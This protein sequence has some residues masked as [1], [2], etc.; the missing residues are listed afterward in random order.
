MKNLNLLLLFFL[1]SCGNDSSKSDSVSETNVIA[2]EI[3]TWTD[4]FMTLINDH[5]LTK[6]L[7]PLIHED[8][9]AQIVKIHSENMAQGKV[10]FGH[11]G[12]TARCNEARDA[13]NGGNWCGENVANGQKTP[14]LVFNAW[15]NSSGHKANIE[16]EKAT[17]T[18]F[19]FAKNS[20]GSYYWTQIFLE[21]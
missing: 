2:P 11:D 15:L 14:R 18:G 13:L 7:T 17:H 9:L 6:G 19:S 10:S 3:V 5:R 20:N 21:H 12:F 1:L 8:A 16:K 4:E